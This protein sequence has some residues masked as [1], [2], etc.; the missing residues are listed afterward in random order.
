MFM[1]HRCQPTRSMG[2][3]VSLPLRDA[4]GHLPPTSCLAARPTARDRILRLMSKPRRVVVTGLGAVTS[5]GTNVGD[6]WSALLE[7]R[8]GI[9]P[10]ALFDPSG[11]RTQ[12]AAQVL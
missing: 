4:R 11:Y 6:F 10:F 12:T 8:C 7:G 5:I 9:R 3:N 1:K 2:A